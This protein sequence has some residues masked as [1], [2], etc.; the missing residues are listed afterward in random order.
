MKIDQQNIIYCKKNFE[1]NNTSLFLSAIVPK[2]FVSF[3]ENGAL[4]L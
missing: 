1:L 4:K 3:A 2:T